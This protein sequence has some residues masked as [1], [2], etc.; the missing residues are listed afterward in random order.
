M[1][2]AV[3]LSTWVCVILQVHAQSPLEKRTPLPAELR[4]L[5]HTADS[6]LRELRIIY[7]IEYRENTP[8]KYQPERIYYV[9]QYLLLFQHIQSTAEVVAYTPKHIKQL[10]GKPDELSKKPDADHDFSFY[11]SAV[12]KRYI[13]ISNVRYRFYF[14]NNTVQRVVR[15]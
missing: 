6:I 1:F 13:N 10:F 4:K 7:E 8:G 14:K 2:K 11:Y 12:E 9:R 3:F 15:E 5:K